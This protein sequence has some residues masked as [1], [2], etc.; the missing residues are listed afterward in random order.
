MSLPVRSNTGRVLRMSYLVAGVA[1]LGFF[2]LSVLILGVWPGRVLE[3]QTRRMSPDHPLALTASEQRGRVIYAREGCAYC[4]T[5]QVR[6]LA[7]DAARF[8]APTLAW[9]TRFDYPHLWGTRRIGPDLS[10]E[11]SVRAADWQFSHLYSPRSI[12]PDSVMPAYRGLFDGASD[13][14]T[15]EARDLLAYI[16]TL[17][18]AREL[19]GPEGEARAR[20]ASHNME[21]MEVASPVLNASP[22]MTRRQG[23]HPQLGAVQD[24]GRGMDIYRRHCAGCHG[25]GGEGD[26]D[27]ASGL[28]P[29]PANLAEH[30][31]TRDRLS[32]ALWNGVAGTAMPAW[33]DLPVR[34][35]AEVAG[36][37]RTFHAERG[38]PNL[39]AQVLELGARVYTARCAQCHGEKGAGDGWAVREL[40]VVPTNFVAERPSLAESLR[41]LRN[42]IEGTPMAP[43]T[44][45]LSE[46]DLS[47]VAYYVRGF[48]QPDGLANR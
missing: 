46:A 9:E 37:I 12:V 44:G 39:P 35:L 40:R 34:D 36:V 26:G 4:H 8:G 42:G 3:E 29:R 18:R 22:A 6:Y 13:R 38:E 15:Q 2:A 24:P 16:E 7:A 5:Q 1:G 45:Q 48:Y 47:A 19:A 23:N 14:P 27:G 10:R 25:M 20:A 28:E 32:F 21:L 33:R 17:G 41:A 11:G 30:E 43:W 31:Y